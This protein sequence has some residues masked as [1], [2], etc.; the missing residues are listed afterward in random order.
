MD[1][2]DHRLSPRK[3]AGALGSP[4]NAYGWFA[5]EVTGFVPPSEGPQVPRHEQSLI[6]EFTCFSSLLHFFGH[7]E[8]IDMKGTTERFFE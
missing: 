1:V 5:T 8:L 2:R 6:N 3:L 4:E 7:M